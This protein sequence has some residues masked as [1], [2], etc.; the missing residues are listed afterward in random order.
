[1]YH[2]STYSYK[3]PRNVY[4]ITD[5][6]EFLLLCLIYY[7]VSY[8]CVNAYYC[9]IYRIKLHYWLWYKYYFS[10]YN[11]ILKI[12]LSLLGTRSYFK[13]FL[14]FH[15]R[16]IFSQ[17]LKYTQYSTWYLYTCYEKIP[18]LFKISC[19][20]SPASRQP[21]KV[22]YIGWDY[23]DVRIIIVYGLYSRKL[24]CWYFPL[25]IAHHSSVIYTTV[26]VNNFFFFARLPYHRPIRNKS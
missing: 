12:N 6:C 24:W 22:Q 10:M 11:Y 1:M 26:V 5:Y 2:I 15:F 16:K 14:I 13:N 18:F 7:C 4:P 9:V 20:W 8:L 21:W 3:N 25:V 19:S 23:T 17:N